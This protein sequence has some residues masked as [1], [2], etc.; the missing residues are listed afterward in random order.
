M[1]D[2]EDAWRAYADTPSRFARRL[3]E[4]A[5]AWNIVPQRC[6]S[7]IEVELP[8]RAVRFVKPPSARQVASARR[9]RLTSQ[10]AL[11]A[12]ER[13]VQQGSGEGPAPQPDVEAIPA[14]TPA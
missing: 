9:A 2:A 1:T 10:D 5:R 4:T 14:V 11:G 12:S 6:G 7:G 13:L 3:L 8:L